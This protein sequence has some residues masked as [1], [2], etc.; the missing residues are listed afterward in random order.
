MYD[1]VRRY[2]ER[3]YARLTWRID[4]IN[5]RI[6]SVDEDESP[7]TASALSVERQRVAMKRSRVSAKLGGV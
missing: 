7:E 4:T 6:N 1:F 5:E 3:K 2:R